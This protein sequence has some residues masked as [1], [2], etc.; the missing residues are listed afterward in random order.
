[1][2]KT[3]R[4]LTVVTP[5][6]ST[7]IVAVSREDTAFAFKTDIDDVKD[8]ILT[9]GG[10]VA[11]FS[12]VTTAAL[13]S[14]S[15]TLPIYVSTS[16]QSAAF[17]AAGLGA[18]RFQGLTTSTTYVDLGA[19]YCDFSISSSVIARISDTSVRHN[20]FAGYATPTTYIDLGTTIEF[21][22]GGAV[23]A[24]IDATGLIVDKVYGET[25]ATNYL[26]LN[27]VGSSVRLYTNSIATVIS[28]SSGEIDFPYRSV[29]SAYG[30]A[31]QAIPLAS[32]T[33]LLFGTETLDPLGQ[34]NPATS[35]LTMSRTG[36]KIQFTIQLLFLSQAFTLPGFGFQLYYIDNLSPT[37]NEASAYFYFQQATYAASF[38][39][40][41]VFISSTSAKEFRM[42]SNTTT[43]I[44]VKRLDM[45][46]LQ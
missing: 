14:P 31:N 16:T 24:E 40:T 12:E 21:Y 5:V 9:S 33:K 26:D 28:H 22:V 19:T 7:H 4:E 37:Y 25:T 27:A 34:Y 2:S 46:I 45:T 32:A 36:A 3:F 8:Y 17:S 13:R 20:R 11:E 29:V 41:G 39:F 44:D 10:T 43:T 15:S 1:M 35:V 42:L 38:V 30:T 23:V 6:I 18:D